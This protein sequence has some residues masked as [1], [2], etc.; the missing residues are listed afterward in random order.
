MTA[1]AMNFKQVS[2]KLLSPH[3]GQLVFR[4]AMHNSFFGFWYYYFA[5]INRCFAP[6]EPS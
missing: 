2:R 1:N 4:P 3:V 5:Y 6:G